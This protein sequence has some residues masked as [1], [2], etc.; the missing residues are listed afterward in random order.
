MLIVW[1]ALEWLYPTAFEV[2]FGGATPGKRS[3][4]LIVLHDDGTPVRLPAS[5]TRNLLRAVDFMP[6]LY[7]FGLVS[8][9]LSRDFKRLGDIAA[10]TVV[11]YREAA[12]QHAA[13]PHAPPVPPPLPLP[14]AEQRAVLDLATRSG[15]L[16]AERA[17]ELAALV[18]APDRRAAR[19][20]RAAAAHRHRQLPDRTPSMKQQ[21]FEAAH[22][23]RWEQF[24]DWLDAS[25]ALRTSRARAA[26]PHHR[27]DAR[28]RRAI[29]SCASTWRSPATAS[30]AR[31]LIERLSR[32]ALAGHQRLYGAHGD[33][34][35]QVATFLLRGFPERR[36][37]ALALRA[38]G[39]PAVLRPAAGADRRAA[40]LSRV[41]LRRHPAGAGGE[42][43]Q[44]C[45]ATR[46]RSSAASARRAMT[47][48]CSASTSGT[49]CA[50]ASRPSPAASLFGLGA[51]FYLLFN[52][53]YIGTVTG[54][55]VYSGFAT[56][57]FSFTSGHSAFE[58]DR[59]RLVRGGRPAARL[60]AGRAG[61]AA[62]RRCA[63]PGCARGAAAGDRRG[64]HA[65][66]GGRRSRRSGRRAR[67]SRRR[68]S[69]RSAACSGW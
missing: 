50:S 9:L 38:G 5:L 41:R 21:D 67:R 59:H 19:R 61:A 27:A 30:T 46:P 10:G 15:S 6:L 4:G 52:G 66:A 13:V 53:L 33:A 32:L 51:L 12:V 22:A 34:R 47:R 60:R 7:G 62:A 57:F 58:L 69:T 17:E 54:Y 37:R 44:R 45:T 18:A 68:S 2:W 56:N 14:L 3:L 29:A 42:L 64:L 16:T 8:M 49:M 65:G 63:A 11:V 43:R 28:C 20:G 39:L 36:A 35:A 55:V 23:A 31:E 40:A 26:K 1:F 48:S 25:Q 24:S